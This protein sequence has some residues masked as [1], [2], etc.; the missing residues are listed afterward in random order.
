MGGALAIDLASKHSQEVRTYGALNLHHISSQRQ[1]SALIVENTFMS[2]VRQFKLD[3]SLA[4]ERD[5]DLV[6]TA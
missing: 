3:P 1:V 4:A 5:T 6:V 2:L